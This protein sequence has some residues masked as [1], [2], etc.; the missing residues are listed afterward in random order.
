MSLGIW[1]TLPIFIIYGILTGTFCC[2]YDVLTVL[3]HTLDIVY[4]L[5][6]KY[7]KKSYVELCHFALGKPGYI[8]ACL[9]IFLFN[10][11]TLVRPH[12]HTR[13]FALGSDNCP[14]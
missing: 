2:Y 14:T 1:L 10:Y 9:F 8:A 3:V 6:N 4:K 13:A 12:T 7:R 5:A 11:G